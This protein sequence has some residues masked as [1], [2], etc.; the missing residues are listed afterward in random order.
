M[1]ISLPW[2]PP[3]LIPPPF[4]TQA[5]RVPTKLLTSS[6]LRAKILRDLATCLDRNS[7][8]LL[9]HIN[10]AFSSHFFGCAM[11]CFCFNSLNVAYRGRIFLLTQDM[12]FTQS[13]TFFVKQHKCNPLDWPLGKFLGTEISATFPP[14]QHTASSS[15]TCDCYR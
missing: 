6:S 10:C 14:L 1:I 13:K 12:P 5:C 8:A 7:C 3:T 9:C 4:H 15:G 2:L 11:F